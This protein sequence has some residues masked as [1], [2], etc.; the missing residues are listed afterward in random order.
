MATLQPTTRHAC[1]CAIEGAYRPRWWTVLAAQLTAAAVYVVAV[2]IGG[3]DL[4]ARSGESTVTIDIGLIM[5]V[6]LIAGVAAVLWLMA[7]RRL[8]A[9]PDRNWAVT[10]GIVLLLSLTGPAGATSVAAGI[11]L[12]C[13]HLGFAG[14]LAAGSLPLHRA[15]LRRL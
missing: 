13:M 9:R 12:A 1:S 11:A 7:L 5:S 8:T 6:S 15:Q 4:S 10:A 3:V 2:P 14:V